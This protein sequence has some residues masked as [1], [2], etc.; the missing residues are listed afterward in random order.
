MS[1]QATSAARRR[2]NF[3][4]VTSDG[5]RIPRPVRGARNLSDRQVRQIVDGMLDLLR[6]RGELP[7]RSESQGERD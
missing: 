7:A 3:L 4:G 5:V 2:Q 1:R 6:E